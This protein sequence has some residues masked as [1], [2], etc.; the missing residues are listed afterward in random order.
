V[1]RVGNGLFPCAMRGEV[2]ISK[3]AQGL[4]ST[5]ALGIEIFV[6]KRPV[7]RRTLPL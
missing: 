5:F 4:A 3:S 1:D 2:A 6:D 7:E